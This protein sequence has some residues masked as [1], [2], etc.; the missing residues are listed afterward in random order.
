M[1][2]IS[3][4]KAQ[5]NMLELQPIMHKPNSVWS[6]DWK[7]HIVQHPNQKKDL[8]QN[9]YII[10]NDI[11]LVVKKFCISFLSYDLEPV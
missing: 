10:E 1:E 5:G 9:C 6:E 4:Q 7:K 8:L 2:L 11:I 3:A